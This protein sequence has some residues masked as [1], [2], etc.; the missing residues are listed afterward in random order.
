V[1][2]NNKIMDVNNKYFYRVYGLN[3][4]SNIEISEFSKR[5]EDFKDEDKVSILYGQISQDI[6]EEIKEGKRSNIT[7]EQVWFHIDQVA[8]Y[9]IK[10]GN[11][12]IIEPCENCNECLMKVYIMGS[13]LGLLLLQREVTAIHGG[14]IIIDGK[15]VIFTGE[16][17]AGKSTLTTAFGKKGYSF[18]SDDVAALNFD[19]ELAI[20]PGFPYHKLC[21]DAL[22]SMNY[23]MEDYSFFQADGIIKYL[24]PDFHGFYKEK[25]PITSICELTVGDVENV[26]V[27]EIVGGEKLNKIIKN[28]YRI[29]YLGSMGGMTPKYLKKCIEVAKKIKFYKITRPK[30]KYTVDTQIEVIEDI[31]KEK[32]EYKVI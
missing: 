1:K 20:E 19:N 24:V 12:V 7:K 8:T 32:T 4:N 9:F 6:L 31:F 15:A 23:Y 5:D 10:N 30:N 22:E 29:E 11:T 3:I 2:G 21:V 14:T 27:E 28:I 26:Q 16:R 25:V 13:V 17:G 18:L